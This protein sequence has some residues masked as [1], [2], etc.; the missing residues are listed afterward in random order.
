MFRNLEAFMI[1]ATLII[2]F[3]IVFQATTFAQERDI[4]DFAS[5]HSL[6]QQVKSPDGIYRT[7]KYGDYELEQAVE[8]L[9]DYS[10]P[11]TVPKV[12]SWYSEAKDEKIRVSLLR[13][14]AASR[15]ARAAL[16]LGNLLKDDWLSIRVAATYG[17]K[18]YFIQS[19]LGR[20]TEDHMLAV[21]AWWEKNQERLEAEAKRIDSDATPNNSMDVRAKQLLS[22]CVRN[23]RSWDTW[24]SF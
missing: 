2:V 14:L 4:L 12:I 3:V 5:K 19:Y 11:L 15:D 23:A 13:V 8:Q 1:R 16:V 17:L 24:K 21:Q 6:M 9:K 20:S 18:D 22:C 7:P 10:Q